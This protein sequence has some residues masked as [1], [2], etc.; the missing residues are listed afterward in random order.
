MYTRNE[1]LYIRPSGMYRKIVSLYSRDIRN[2]SRSAA[3]Y[4]FF[5]KLYI[6]AGREGVR[7]RFYTT[8]SRFYTPEHR[9]ETGRLAAHLLPD[10]D[11]LGTAWAPH[12][13]GE[14]RRRRFTVSR[15]LE[16]RADQPRFGSLP[17]DEG[18]ADRGLLKGDREV[19]ATAGKPAIPLSPTRVRLGPGQPKPVI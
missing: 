9:Q 13:I 17:A 6:R 15:S 11:R 14:P 3:L 12:L 10:A 19:V 7:R 4:R 2:H 18:E 16:R 8:G 1:S 5:R